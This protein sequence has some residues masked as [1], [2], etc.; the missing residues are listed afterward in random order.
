M[1]YADE[2]MDCKKLLLLFLKKIWVVVLAAVLG[3]A[4]GGGIYMFHSVALSGNREYQATSKLYLYFAHDETGDAYQ[5]YNGYTWNDLMSTDKILN[6]TMSYL[7]D[8]YTRE[9]VAAA[10]E[11]S[12][13][14]DIR[15]LTIDITTPNPEKTI[16]ILSATNKALVEMGERER[17]FTGIEVISVSDAELVIA[18]SRLFQ[19]VLLGVAGMVI[20]ALIA[21]A[22]VYVLDDR[23]YVPGD[24][25]C[26]TNLPFI[27]FQFKNKPVN[28]NNSRKEKLFAKLCEDLEQNRGYME[29]ANEILEMLEL[30]KENMITAELCEKLRKSDGIFLVIPYGQMDRASLAYR[31]EQLKLQECKIVGI[32]IKDADMRFMKWY[33]NHL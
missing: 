4:I 12:I 27:G 25:K 18:D 6:I 21:M 26:V 5:A 33:Y 16:E 10:T 17:E 19:A 3:A 32:I 9:E 20:L 2:G 15:L 13:L 1:K 8:T 30:G 29:K 11:A 7:P 31:I 14:S 23:I 22:L 24:L 28:I